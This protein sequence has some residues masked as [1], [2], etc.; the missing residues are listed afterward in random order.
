MPRGTVI[1]VIYLLCPDYC[2]SEFLV[3][4]ESLG[5]QVSPKVFI[6]LC[7]W[8]EHFALKGK[9]K[10]VKKKGQV[11]QVN[12][13]RVQVICELLTQVNEGRVQVICVITQVKEGRVQVI[14]NPTRVNKGR[15]KVKL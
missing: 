8:L 14:C 11:T 5:T 1:F 15:V 9:E 2:K 4:E 6:Q 10:E 3:R 7:L 13:G 12:E